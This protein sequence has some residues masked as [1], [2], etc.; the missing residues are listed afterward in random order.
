MKTTMILAWQPCSKQLPPPPN[1]T[2]D[3]QLRD[4]FTFRKVPLWIVFSNLLHPTINHIP[5]LEYGN[6]LRSCCYSQRLVRKILWHC[7]IGNRPTCRWQLG[8]C[9]PPP[10]KMKN[11]HR[12]CRRLETY[13]HTYMVVVEEKKP[14]SN[15]FFFFYFGHSSLPMLQIRIQFSRD[16]NIIVDVEVVRSGL[17]F[18]C[19]GSLMHSH[20]YLYHD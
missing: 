2:N 14:L 9:S 15:T 5:L 4:P 19:I 18:E 6:L 7:R 10:P 17:A 8:S 1:N 16:A 3:R 13:I 20:W 11:H 12:F